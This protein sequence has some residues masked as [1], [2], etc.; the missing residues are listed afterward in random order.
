M[1]GYQLT[2]VLAYVGLGVNAAIILVGI[3][4]AVIAFLLIKRQG[5]EEI[6]KAAAIFPTALESINYSE[7]PIGIVAVIADHMQITLEE[8]AAEYA[9][10]AAQRKV[11]V[12][13]TFRKDP[14]TDNFIENFPSKF[15]QHG[16]V[17]EELLLH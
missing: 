10:D 3:I 12:L 2:V 6:N 9:K 11:L 15:I 4:T 5:L 14:V 7:I 8:V 13:Q 16:Y 1:E 17:G